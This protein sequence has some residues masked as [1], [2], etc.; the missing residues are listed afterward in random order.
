MLTS[1]IATT[2][3]WAVF[4]LGAKS[5]NG[6][7]DAIST[8]H[9]SLLDHAEVDNVAVPVQILSPEHD[10]MYTEELKAYTNKVIPSLGVEYDY[11]Y[12]PALTHGFAAR[13]DP[14]DPVQKKGLERAKNAVTHWFTEHLH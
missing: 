13:G 12:F 8:A 7:V 4:K 10:A 6:L 3:G 9:P 1:G 11:Q 2:G 5:E 14:N